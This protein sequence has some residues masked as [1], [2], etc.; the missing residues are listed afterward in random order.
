MNTPTQTN[1]YRILL[2]DDDDDRIKLIGTLLEPAHHQHVV[3]VASDYNEAIEKIGGNDHAAYLVSSDFSGQRGL[4]VIWEISGRGCK[5]PAL[6]ISQEDSYEKE[7]EAFNLGAMVFLTWDQ[8]QSR[9]LERMIRHAIDRKRQEDNI[10]NEQEGLIGRM[11]DIQDTRDRFEA[12]SAEY[13]EMAEELASAQAELQRALDEVTESKQELEQLN[14]EKDRFFSIISHDLRS[15]FTSLL[16]Y[17]GLIAERADKLSPEQIVDYASNINES[18]KRVFALLENLLEWARLQMDQIASEP[19]SL[20]IGAIVERTVRVLGPVGEDKGVTVSAN[21]PDGLAC[22]ADEHMI[23]TVVRNL[24]NNAIKF[25]PEGGA[26][27]VAG[28]R[29]GDRCELSVTDTGVGLAPDRIDKLFSLG[30]QNSTTGTKGEK[31]TGLG[32]LLCRDLLDKNKGTITV[33]SEPGKGS[34]FTI[35]LPQA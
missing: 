26:V 4:E 28:R 30:D 9:F 31:G 29:H 14:L 24:V 23:D 21:I 3:E 16:G 20:D 1:T 34:T 12:Q 27:T 6:L 35:Y 15:P 17:T 18:A 8:L 5:G 22:F 10:R 2:I 32:L 19:K 33:T 11:M 7:D 25:T 13:V